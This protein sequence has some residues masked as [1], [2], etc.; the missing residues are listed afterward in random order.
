MVTR[1][2]GYPCLPGTRVPGFGSASTAF[3]PVGYPVPMFEAGV[4]LYYC[5]QVLVGVF[6][7]FR[8]NVCG[9]NPKQ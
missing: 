3:H 1:V 2:P 9:G 5:T 6:Q 8:Q 7:K 4:Q